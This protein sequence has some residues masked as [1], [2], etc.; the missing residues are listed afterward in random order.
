MR[1]VL[2]QAKAFAFDVW[3]HWKA[4]WSMVQ[5][6]AAADGEA[7][8]GAP[9]RHCGVGGNGHPGLTLRISAHRWKS[10]PNE[11][12]D[13][14]NWSPSKANRIAL[15]TK[16]RHQTYRGS[17][18]RIAGSRSRLRAGPE[19][20]FHRGLTVSESLGTRSAAACAGIMDGR[21]AARRA[22]TGSST[23]RSNS[24]RLSKKVERK[25]G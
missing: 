18:G 25:N 10:T 21:C 11:A 3:R 9:F 7:G 15:G 17:K 12:L 1:I 2:R 20:C 4:A 16:R 23:R 5:Q 13:R 8:A 22:A 24:I 19:L 6:T 14:R